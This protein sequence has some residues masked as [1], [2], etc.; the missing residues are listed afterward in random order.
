MP[1]LHQPAPF[2]KRPTDIVEACPSRHPQIR[3]VPV[4][5]RSRTALWRR[6]SKIARCMRARS[7]R[8]RRTPIHSFHSCSLCSQVQQSQS[9]RPTGDRWPRGERCAR[10]CLV[11]VKEVRRRLCWISTI[12]PMRV[13]TAALSGVDTSWMRTGRT[14][15]IGMTCLSSLAKIPCTRSSRSQRI[16][17]QNTRCARQSPPTPSNR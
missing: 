5:V 12:T 14:S 10:E 2:D 17:G 3:V 16:L 13:H 4:T 9:S 8:Q 7:R 11:G 6:R 1:S 15:L